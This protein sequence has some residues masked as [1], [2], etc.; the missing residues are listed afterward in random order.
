M[1]YNIGKSIEI[2]EQTPKTLRSFLEN[3]SDD[4]VFC[5]EG[6]NTWS[7]Y[8]IV[9]HLIHGE[10]TDWI[11]RLHI[12]L[13]NSDEK[14]F[15]PFDRFAQFEDSKGKSLSNLLDEFEVLRQ[16][17]LNTL[18]D[19]NVSNAQLQYKGIH[20]ELGEVTLSQLLATWVTH[21]LGHIAQI[22][23]V[24]A[25]QYKTQVGPWINYISIL[26]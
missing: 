3:L 11:P 1:E 25:K 15:K 22:S 20:P 18:K 17:N 2:L 19:L 16:H 5:N 23:R 7:A 24:M 14:V 12:I 21:D 13:S 9:G 26:N 4:W 6:V 10:K 8:D